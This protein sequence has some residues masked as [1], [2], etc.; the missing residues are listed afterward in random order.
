MTTIQ[1]IEKR[2]KQVESRNR[3]VTADKA[4]ETSATRRLSIAVLTYIVVSLYLIAIHKD[5]PFINALVPVIGYLLST[6]AL[7]QVKAKWISRF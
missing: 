7:A 5:Q 3:K 1:E 4:W 2:L 6:L